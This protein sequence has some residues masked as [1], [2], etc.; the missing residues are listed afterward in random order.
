MIILD[1]HGQARGTLP[2]GPFER[3]QLFIN[4]QGH[5]RGILPYGKKETLLFFSIYGFYTLTNVN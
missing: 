5:A 2:F 4:T 1:T 3:Y